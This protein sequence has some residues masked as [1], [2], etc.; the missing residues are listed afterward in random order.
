MPLE[1]AGLKDDLEA[2]FADP[3]TTSEGCATKW[4]DAVGAYAA[5]IVPP[6]TTVSAARDALE[7]AVLGAIGAPAV[8][9]GMEA[10]F[11]AFAVAVGSGQAGFVPTP[12]PAPVG[13]ATALLPPFPTTHADAAGRWGDLINDWLTS[14]SSTPVAG[15][16]AVP[17]S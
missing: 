14:G 4:A 6:S 5:G 12:P 2:F 3:P 15:G 7:G 10:A 13:F 8:A 16:P 9:P 1:L 11:A 17:W